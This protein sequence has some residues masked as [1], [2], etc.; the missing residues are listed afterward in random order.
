[1]KLF[2]IAQHITAVYQLFHQFFLT[3]IE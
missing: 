3:I 2:F 1:M